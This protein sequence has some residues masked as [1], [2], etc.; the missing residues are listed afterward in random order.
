MKKCR[1]CNKEK[2]LTCFHKH[3]RQKD[4]HRNICKDCKNKENNTVWNRRQSGYDCPS[5]SVYC[6]KDGDEI[7]YIGSSAFTSRRLYL[8]FESKKSTHHSFIG[9]L[10]PLFRKVKY[11]WAILWNGDSNEDRAHQEKM[12]IQIHQPKFNKI[13]YKNYEG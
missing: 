4:G 8:H 10:A 1:V 9:D 6:I 12:L 3:I 2:D 11:K 13:K 7:V 5:N